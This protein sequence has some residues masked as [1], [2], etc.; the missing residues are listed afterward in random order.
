MRA[1]ESPG[2][3]PDFNT[4][5]VHPAEAGCFHRARAKARAGKLKKTLIGTTEV[6]P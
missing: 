5:I 3:K 4:P 6:V 2:L 1:A